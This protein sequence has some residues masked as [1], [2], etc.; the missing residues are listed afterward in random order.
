MFLWLLWTGFW[1]VPCVVSQ[2]IFMCL[3]FSE[4]STP[5]KR[6]KHQRS[7]LKKHPKKKKK[8]IKTQGFVVKQY[9]LVNKPL[10]IKHIT[11]VHKKTLKTYFLTTRHT[12]KHMNESGKNTYTCETFCNPLNLLFLSNKHQKNLLLQNT[13]THE[14]TIAFQSY[15]WKTWIILN[16]F[17]A[18]VDR[19][20]KFMH[21]P[22]NIFG[23]T[24]SKPPFV[25]LS[26]ADN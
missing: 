11:H 3:L 22:Q 10:K 26:F 19:F 8:T 4:R 25:F 2:L 7:S 24:Y 18:M 14:T 1:F 13:K 12:N 9:A 21:I 17:E 6:W 20:L 16:T 5:W 23:K 15:K